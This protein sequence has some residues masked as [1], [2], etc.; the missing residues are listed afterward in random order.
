MPA[1]LYMAPKFQQARLVIV[2]QNA[3]CSSNH[4]TCRYYST[5]FPHF[6]Q[7]LLELPIQVFTKKK[8]PS[9]FLGRQYSY[10]FVISFCSLRSLFLLVR[11]LDRMYRRCVDRVAKFARKM[12]GSCCCSMNTRV[13]SDVRSNARRVPTGMYKLLSNMQF[14]FLYLTFRIGHASSFCLSC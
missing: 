1:K 14:F 2:L 12:S 5:S 13:P 9:T 10:I 6:Q 3:P 8:W 4:N 7:V 11:F